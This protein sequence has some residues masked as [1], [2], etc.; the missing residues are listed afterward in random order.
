MKKGD[1][2]VRIESLDSFD[3]SFWEYFFRKSG[4]NNKELYTKT[5]IISELEHPLIKLDGYVYGFNTEL[6]RVVNTAFS[7]EAY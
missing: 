4:L 5:F 1:T 2:V 6:F 7:Y 3:S